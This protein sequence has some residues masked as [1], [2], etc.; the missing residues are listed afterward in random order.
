MRYVAMI[1]A[2][3]GSSRLP[4]KVCMS[5]Q[6]K[7]VIQWVVERV[8]KSSHVEDALV[9]T[10]IQKENLPLVE[11]CAGR[12]IRVFAGAE[13]D[14]LDRYYQ[15]AKLLAPE[16]IIRVT[17]DCPCYDWR[18]LDAAIEAMPSAADYCAD[19]SETL[20]DGYDIEIIR[21]SALQ[22]AWQA[23]ALPSEREHVT[24]YIKAHPELFRLC[25]FSSP[26]EGV[27]HLRLTL[28]EPADFEVLDHVYAHFCEQG[29]PYFSMEEATTYLKDNPALIRRNASIVRN[30]GLLRSIEAEQPHSQE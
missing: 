4:G 1:Q 19:F 23:A 25:N 15:A 9:L 13:E 7:P 17:A 29:N 26:V 11:L 20:P 5:L 10:S 24:P 12:G 8:Q 21:F 22:Q 27:G 30:E 14:V 28:D 18:V 3:I 6:G 2:R 16:Y